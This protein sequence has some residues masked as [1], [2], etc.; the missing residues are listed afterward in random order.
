MIE[1]FSEELQ[2]IISESGSGFLLTLVAAI[3]EE[4]EEREV[5]K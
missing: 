2:E 3:K 1:K 5:G 4:L